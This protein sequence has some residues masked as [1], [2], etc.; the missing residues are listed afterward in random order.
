MKINIDFC[1]AIYCFPLN[2]RS[3]ELSLFVGFQMVNSVHSQSP[4]VFMAGKWGEWVTLHDAP[5]GI[6]NQG[7]FLLWCWKRQE[8]RQLFVLTLTRHRVTQSGLSSI[9][10]WP[11]LSCSWCNFTLA[12]TFHW[13]HLISAAVRFC[14]YHQGGNGLGLAWAQGYP[15]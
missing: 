2:F 12:L 4:R 9:T 6:W 8:D 7:S 13:V 1:N 10:H 3:Q 11:H 5:S 15:G 14:E